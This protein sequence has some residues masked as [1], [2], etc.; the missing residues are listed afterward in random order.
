MFNPLIFL[1]RIHGGGYSAT[2]MDAAKATTLD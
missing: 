1:S 2:T